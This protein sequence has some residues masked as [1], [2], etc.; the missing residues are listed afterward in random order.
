[1]CRK[2]VKTGDSNPIEKFHFVSFAFKSLHVRKENLKDRHTVANQDIHPQNLR[3][4]KRYPE[5]IIN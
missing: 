1:M 5:T 3:Y 2:I 4:S